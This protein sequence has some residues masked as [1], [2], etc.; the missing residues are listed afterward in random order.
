MAKNT[1]FSLSYRAGVVRDVSRKDCIVDFLAL[2]HDLGKKRGKGA[3]DQVVDLTEVDG[4]LEFAGKTVAGRAA[5]W[6]SAGRHVGERFVHATHSEFD[7]MRELR[8]EQEKIRHAFGPDRG[9]MLLAVRFESRTEFEK[10]QPVEIFARLRRIGEI[11]SAGAEM[12]SEQTADELGALD[13][14]AE[15]QEVP[16]LSVPQRCV[17][18]ALERVQVPEDVAKE[19]RGLMHPNLFDGE[20]LQVKIQAIEMLPH[21]RGKLLAHLTR[22]VARPR[23]RRGQR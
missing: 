7:R 22:I 1:K 5:A 10:H 15:L 9:R 14:A 11:R 19:A 20:R 2:A 21:F 3:A 16:S 4:S 6:R 17:D 8:I 18:D 13:I 23:Q 12:D